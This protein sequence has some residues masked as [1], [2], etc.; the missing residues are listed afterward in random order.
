VLRFTWNQ[1]TERPLRVAARIAQT[2][3]VRTP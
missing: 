1:V 3:G 2:V